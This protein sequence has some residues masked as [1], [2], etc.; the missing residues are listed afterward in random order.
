[1]SCTWDHTH[2][3]SCTP[4]LDLDDKVLGLQPEPDAWVD[5]TLMS[6]EREGVGF[7]MKGDLKP[8]AGKRIL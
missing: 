1:M 5:K 4:E 8:A 2:G 7:R 3:A 6:L